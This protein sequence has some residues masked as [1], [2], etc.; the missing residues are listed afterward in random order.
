MSICLVG[1]ML[2]FVP[3]KWSLNL[4]KEKSSA[5]A[6]WRKQYKTG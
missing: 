5:P 3:V 6:H 1:R 4:L 2:L